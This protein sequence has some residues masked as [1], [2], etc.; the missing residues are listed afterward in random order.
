MK[1]LKNVWIYRWQ[2][3]LVQNKN[4]I[5]GELIRLFPEIFT[6]VSARILITESLM[7][8]Y[9]LVTIKVTTRLTLFLPDLV[10]WRSY[11]GWFR[12][13][14]VGIGLKHST[15]LWDIQGLLE[16]LSR[17]LVVLALSPYIKDLILF[18][19]YCGKHAT[20]SCFKTNSEHAFFK[21]FPADF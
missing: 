7:D 8:K 3:I 12:P 17:I 1:K 13:W 15:T 20:Q 14:P 11:M 6:L 5:V 16:L 4:P 2:Q 18:L 19:K 9:C 10:T 21:T